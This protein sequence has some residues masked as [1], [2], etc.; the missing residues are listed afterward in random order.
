MTTDPYAVAVNT[1]NELITRKVRPLSS[2]EATFHAIE[3]MSEVDARA[4][5]HRLIERRYLCQLDAD[6][7]QFL[8]QRLGV[9]VQWSHMPLIPSAEWREGRGP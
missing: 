4:T 8:A 9:Q 6:I 2:L 5:L 1:I 3:A 7:A